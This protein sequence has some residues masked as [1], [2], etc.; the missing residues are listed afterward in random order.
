MNFI[1]MKFL[2]FSVWCV[3]FLSSMMHATF[4][5]KLNNIT[6][7][8]ESETFTIT[9]DFNTDEYINIDS[10][11]VSALPF[12]QYVSINFEK[13]PLELYIPKK[14]NPILVLHGS[15]AIKFVVPGTDKDIEN[16][17]VSYETYDTKDNV[18][19]AV[20]TIIVP[21]QNIKQETIEEI[22]N[23]PEVVLKKIEEEKNND[24]AKNTLSESISA[25]EFIKAKEE[26]KS[27][28]LEK[29]ADV[30]EK[31]QD[32]K[33]TFTDLLISYM[34]KSNN[35]FILIIIV[36]LIGFLMSFTPC[37]Y[38]MI[39]ITLGVLSIDK[40]KNKREALL[41]AS[42]Y[43]F[44][45]AAT[46]VLLGLLAISGKMIFGSLLSKQWFL[47]GLLIFF[48]Y[49]TG[50][51]LGF[52]DIMLPAIKLNFMSRSTIVGPFLYGLAS[53]TITSPCVSPG[54]VALLTLVTEQGDYL[55]GSLLLFLFGL[56]LGLPLWVIAVF[57]NGFESLPRSGV[58]M[59]E[60]KKIIG[61]IL[62]FVWKSY[63]TIL[64]APWIVYILFVFV[65]LIYS[66][67]NIYNALAYYFN[68]KYYKYYLIG[69]GLFSFSGV[70]YFG[71]NGYKMLLE[72]SL[73]KK[74][75]DQ[76]WL[77][78]LES[79][80]AQAKNE[81]K[82]VL[83]DCTASWCSL[84]KNVDKKFFSNIL[85]WNKTADHVVAVKLNCSNMDD[86]QTQSFLEEYNIKGLPAILI[87]DP[88]TLEVW[89]QFDSRVCNWDVI[90]FANSI[91]DVCSD[92]EDK[93]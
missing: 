66:V 10:L 9:C 8:Q 73:S 87:L 64:I 4:S 90:M 19:T 34:Q 40:T 26:N 55:Y 92:S 72:N 80:I 53:G 35:S 48:G 44:G 21:I 59:I 82:K 6:H 39:P 11:V 70:G 62:L 33:V 24:I 60:I 88:N 1:R 38:P 93:N 57:F 41:K 58:W 79:G 25:D 75:Y 2:F 32:V 30:H 31:A 69:L 3:V 50:S 12:E 37:M 91:I 45:I 36:F 16:L 51:M 78:D 42:A 65:A 85:F 84:C 71:Y 43:V 18:F 28:E 81:N 83:V 67:F 86:V 49:L 23:L 77:Y 46:F 27:H 14:K 52:Y 13:Q 56:G 15:G 20:K 54:L 29:V 47:I 61:I 63:A 7:N 5:V 89:G 76:Y 74:N 68:T 22:K 17:I